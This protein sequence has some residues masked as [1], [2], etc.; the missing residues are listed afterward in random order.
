MKKYEALKIDMFSFDENEVFTIS[1]SLEGVD[2]IL[3]DGW[4][5]GIR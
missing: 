2:N 1:E 5:N 3:T 4:D